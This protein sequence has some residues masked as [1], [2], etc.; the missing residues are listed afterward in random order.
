MHTNASFFYIYARRPAHRRAWPNSPLY[1]TP[2]NLS[3]FLWIKICYTLFPIHNKLCVA[4]SLRICYY[5]GVKRR[6]RKTSGKPN[7]GSGSNLAEDAPN[8]E[9]FSDRVVRKKCEKPLDKPQ[10]L[11]YNK[12]V[13]RREGRKTYSS[14][15]NKKGAVVLRLHVR[16]PK[17]DW[18]GS[19]EQLRNGPHVS[20]PHQKLF[21]KKFEKSA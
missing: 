10:P 9:F 2:Q 18:S 4:I 16:E 1:H 17:A 5:N 14:V 19:G 3:N 21:Q 6:A 13:P 8:H 15:S 20:L 11:F 7:E 12:G